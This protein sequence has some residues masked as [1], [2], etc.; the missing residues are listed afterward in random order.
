MESKKQESNATSINPESFLFA[1]GFAADDIPETVLKTDLLAALNR[2]IY[3]SKYT[4]SELSKFLDMP[5]RET[6]ELLAGRA[7]QFTVQYLRTHVDRFGN[8]ANRRSQKTQAETA[9]K[10]D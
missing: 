7:Q 6:L 4:V 3:T 2:Y 10:Q 8:L 9:Q 5:L 1:L